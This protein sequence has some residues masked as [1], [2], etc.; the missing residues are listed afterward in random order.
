MTALPVQCAALIAP[1]L[2]AQFG[3]FI[4]HEVE[5]WNK[6]VQTLGINAD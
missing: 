3:K 4:A 2:P 5:R 1:Y 6:V